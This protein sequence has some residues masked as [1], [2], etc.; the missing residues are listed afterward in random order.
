M[1]APTLATMLGVAV[2]LGYV[3]S[4]AKQVPAPK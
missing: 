1:I 2:V 4:E 3:F